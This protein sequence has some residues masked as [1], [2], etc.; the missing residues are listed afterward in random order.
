MKIERNSD[1]WVERRVTLQCGHTAFWSHDKGDYCPRCERDEKQR[2]LAALQA[3]HEALQSL[4][5]TTLE[6]V[7]GTLGDS[8]ALP[9]VLARLQVSQN[10]GAEGILP[11][12]AVGS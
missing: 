3:K 4:I 9:V 7:L 8:K 6:T 12:S 10:K 11:A 5:S 1:E 2:E